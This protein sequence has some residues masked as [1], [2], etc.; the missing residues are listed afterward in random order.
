MRPVA[1]GA[2][3]NM[4]RLEMLRLLANM[5]GRLC[6]GGGGNTLAGHNTVAAFFKTRMMRSLL[7][8]AA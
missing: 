6:W 2:K 8:G 4:I 5:G 3:W 1:R 7:I